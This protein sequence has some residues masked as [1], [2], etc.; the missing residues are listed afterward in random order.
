MMAQKK[1][2]QNGE[3]TQTDFH[4]LTFADDL[5]VQSQLFAIITVINLLFLLPPHPPTNTLLFSSHD[6]F[7][8]FYCLHS[9]AL[10]L[11]VC[12]H[13]S[14]LLRQRCYSFEHTA[15]FSL[16]WIIRA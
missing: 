5:K 6:R 12:Y 10:S 14:V 13:E 15:G 16:F 11:L 3:H 4:P 2:I 8:S 7:F 9:H 1:W